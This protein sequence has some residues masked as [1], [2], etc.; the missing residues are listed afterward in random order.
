M[1]KILLNAILLMSAISC[2]PKF[3]PVIDVAAKSDTVYVNKVQVDSIYKHDSVFVREKGDTVYIYKEKIRERY[4]MLHDTT[5][6]S[7]TD[8][9]HATIVQEVEKEL[10]GV[11]KFSIYG[12]WILLLSLAVSLAVRLYFRLR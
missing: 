8:T 1:K 5:Y 9:L 6:V 7:H 3:Y 4:K 10:S 11:Q 12:F 2:S